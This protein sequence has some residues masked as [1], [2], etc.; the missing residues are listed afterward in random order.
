MSRTIL[1]I[2]N[3]P[4]SHSSRHTYAVPKCPGHDIPRWWQPFEHPHCWAGLLLELQAS[5]DHWELPQNTLSPRDGPHPPD[6]S[7]LQP[8]WLKK[9]YILSIFR[10]IDK[11]TLK[12]IQEQID[13][14]L[15][16]FNPCLNTVFHNWNSL[17]YARHSM[18]E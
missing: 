17:W 3:F 5:S 14:E 4:L 16:Y 2:I 13:E 10:L 9:G 8:Y 1:L 12:S 11:N 18:L 6:G 7:H 15:P